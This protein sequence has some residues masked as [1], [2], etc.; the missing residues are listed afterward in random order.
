MLQKTLSLAIFQL[1][2]AQQKAPLPLLERGA[3]CGV[4]YL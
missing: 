3:G 4:L 2:G 1:W